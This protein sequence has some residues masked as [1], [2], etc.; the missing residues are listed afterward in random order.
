MRIWIL[1]DFRSLILIIRLKETLEK[2]FENNSDLMF[3]SFTHQGKKLAVFYIPYQIESNKLEKLL[4]TL[5]SEEKEW[6]SETLLN[7]IPLGS[8]KKTS[9]LQQIL[10]KLIV[11]EIFIY[12]E[13]EN[14]AISYQEESREKR[15]LEKAETESLVLGPKIAFTESLETNLNIIRCEIRSP[16]LVLEELTIGKDLPCKVRMIYL[17]TVANDQD[18]QTMRQRLQDL[19]VDMVEDA[20]VLAQYIEDSE[21]NLFP[22]LETTELP[23]R[24][25]FEINE[26]KVGVLVE[27]SPTGIL[28]PATIFSF[29][30]STEDLYM[31]W[32]TGSFLRLL[33]MIAIFLSIIITPLYVAIVSFHYGII[34]TQLLVSI[35]KSRAA[36]PFP[37]LIE[38]LLLEFLI[39][40]L[41]EAGARLPTKVGQTM[42][43]VG[44]IV[45]GQAAVDAGLTS[46]ILIIVVAMSALASFTAPSYLLGTTVRLVRFPLILLSGFLGFYGLMFGLCLLIIHM[47]RT[48]SLGHSYLIP[49]YPLNISDFLGVFIRLPIRYNYKRMESYHPKKLFRFPKK[50]A[51]GKKHMKK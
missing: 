42:G 18:I 29:L 8:G 10:T 37:P 13:N 35:G 22:Q 39:E 28:A 5:L 23:D 25:I 9:D 15:N 17:K 32:Q 19:D 51:L 20:A 16:D 30:K 34:P 31:R 40:L 38:A 1:L 49:V 41:R 11:G 3:S 24:F 33:R 44:G 7:E 14:E 26:G 2:Q 21:T 50:E 12:I 43:I 6:T 47:L 27:N 48:K 4:K 36:V 45:I 46:N